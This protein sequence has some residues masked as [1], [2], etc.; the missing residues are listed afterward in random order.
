VV[1]VEAPA[2]DPLAAFR[3][4]RRAGGGVFI[5]QA[6]IERRNARTL[7]DIM[8][9]VP[10]V[11]VI[12]GENG[13][14]YVSTHFRRVG[15]GG[16]ATDAGLCDMMIYIDGQPFQGAASAAE[17]RVRVEQVSGIEVYASAASVPREFAG[18]DAACGV[19]VVWLKQ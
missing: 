16:G 14:R 3:Q 9:A 19:I 13:M 18:S 7:T 12:P 6:E 11:R 4:R 5:E 1:K 10:G 17:S 2:P 8:R 15:Q